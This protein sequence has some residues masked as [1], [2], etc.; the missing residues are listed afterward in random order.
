MSATQRNERFRERYAAEP[1][2][3]A[4]HTARVYARARALSEL[5]HRHPDEYRSLYEHHLRQYE[6]PAAAAGGVS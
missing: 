5:S 2:L 3:R 6:A 1:D 4:R